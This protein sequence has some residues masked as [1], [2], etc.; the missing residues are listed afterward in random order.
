MTGLTANTSI[1]SENSSSFLDFPI[2]VF[3]ADT[4]CAA[5]WTKSETTWGALQNRLTDPDRM[6]RE[7]ISLAEFTSLKSAEQKKIKFGSAFLGGRLSANEDGTYSRRKENIL[8]CC[9]L[10]LDADNAASDFPEKLRS[11]PYEGAVY[12]TI[13]STHEK[14]RLRIVLL[15][16]RSVSPAE[17]AQVAQAVCHELG[18]V[19]FDSCSWRANQCMLL[20]T[21]LCDT[22]VIQFAT[23]GNPVDPDRYLEKAGTASSA[24]TPLPIKNDTASVEAQAEKMP[25]PRE[26]P[27]VIGAFCRAYSSTEA[28]RTFLPQIFLPANT[29]DRYTYT[30]AD[31]EAGG[32]IYGQMFYSY[33][34]NKDPYAGKLLN[35]FDLVRL[36]LFGHL[37]TDTK[38]G[39]KKRPSFKAML[40]LIAK[41]P[42]VQKE[43]ESKR[44]GVS[45]DQVPDWAATLRRLPNNELMQSDD[46]IQLIM[47]N[48]PEISGKLLFNSLSGKPVVTEASSWYDGPVNPSIGTP[49]NDAI[50]LALKEY[51]HKK[52]WLISKDRLADSITL[53]T[54]RHTFHPVCRLLDNTVWDGVS[55]ISTLLTEYLGA[56]DTY[57]NRRISEIFVLGFVQR[58]RKPGCKF[59]YMLILH[60]KQ[61]IGKSRFFRDFGGDWFIADDST[62]LNSRDSKEQRRGYALVELP[63]IVPFV[64]NSSS[65][66]A[67][68]AVVTMQNYCYR[69]VYARYPVE[70]AVGNIF[71]GTTNETQFLPDKMGARRYLP[72]HVKGYDKELSPGIIAQLLAE[73][74]CLLKK[75]CLPCFTKAEEKILETIQDEVVVSHEW[76][77]ILEHYL[78]TPKPKNWVALGDEAKRE[79][80]EDHQRNGSSLA[81]EMETAVDKDKIYQD[82]VTTHELF[83]VAIG[84]RQENLCR[85]VRQIQ[86]AMEDVSGWEWCRGKRTINGTAQRCFVRTQ[87]PLLVLDDM[88]I[89]MLSGE[90]VEQRLPERA[91]AEA[92]PA[93]VVTEASES[94]KEHGTSEEK[95]ALPYAQRSTA[96]TAS[97]SDTPAKQPDLLL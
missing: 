83:I 40:Q 36:H 66:R 4:P 59:D 13:R 51:F 8:D 43:L 68:N 80:W 2:T 57:I 54:S 3:S 60:G 88:T 67:L 86:M 52:Y 17:Y 25:D 10:A 20:P 32:V 56:E 89:N 92:V 70:Y 15:L 33:H 48:D 23:H 18:A 55:R 81:E 53:Y 34:N 35:S 14:P 47:E 44:R 94:E 39:I 97:C 71:V 69:P 27:G 79:W 37:D 11:L 38:T 50:L 62:E 91:V 19:N 1:L 77:P 24:R 85:S 72:V 31:S 6:R 64:K 41:D 84:G 30:G 5:S 12:S 45:L 22:E 29:P 16:K 75:G 9:V 21:A 95:Q 63:E 58:A 61:G 96:S 49:V 73:A 82:A 26:K 78:K 7:E 42:R 87:D 28:L 65:M 46:N 76:T 90:V 74:D 93:A